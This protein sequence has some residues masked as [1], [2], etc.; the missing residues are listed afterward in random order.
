SQ[1]AFVQRPRQNTS[2]SSEFMFEFDDDE[3]FHVDLQQKQTVWRLPEFGE[4]TSFQAEGA[5]GNIAVLRSNLDILIKRS[6]E[7]PAT[8]VPP[9]LMV[10]PEKAVEVGEPN[11]LICMADDFSP[12]VLKM[13]WL[14][15]G[16]PVTDRVQTMD[17]YPKKNNA[18]RRFSYL[19]FI[20]TLQDDY[21][22]QVEH[23]GLKQPLAKIW[24][25][26]IPEPLP[27]TTE[28]VVCALGLAVG[29]IGIV[30]GT[31]LGVKSKR[32]NEATYRRGAL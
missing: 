15:N 32:K 2:S 25:P 3:I 29:I 14:K 23:W 13:S 30:T 24:N 31:I 10:Y 1:V 6:N 11:I 5:Q 7:T 27:E 17:Y 26:N 21:T 8:N 4:V 22:C 18:F 19:P 16:Q 9:K 20:P 28:N 12:P